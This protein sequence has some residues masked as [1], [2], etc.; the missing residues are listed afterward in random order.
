MERVE[1]LKDTGRFI[2]GAVD[3]GGWIRIRLPQ[4]LR[5]AIVEHGDEDGLDCFIQ[6]CGCRSSKQ[7][8]IHKDYAGMPTER[9]EVLNLID[10]TE[11]VLDDKGLYDESSIGNAMESGNFYALTK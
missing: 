7:I 2:D 11:E 5:E 9:F 10:G 1:S 4:H 3:K 6:L 8:W